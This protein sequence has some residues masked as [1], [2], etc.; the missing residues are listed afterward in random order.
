MTFEK[1]IKEA[2]NASSIKPFGVG[3]GGCINA[4][5]GFLIDDNNHIFV[6]TNSKDG[7]NI[8]FHGEY[9]GL[10]ALHTTGKIIVPKPLKVI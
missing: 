1:A 9:E 3:G 7:A 10:K 6:K 4:G 8:M 5:S 2:F